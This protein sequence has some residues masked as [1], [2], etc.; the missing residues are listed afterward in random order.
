MA[1]EFEP[2]VGDWYEDPRGRVFEVVAVDEAEGAVEI[3]HFDG[4]VEEVDMDTW[5]ELDLQP[6]AEPKDWSG[7]FDDLERDDFGDVD[8]P[9]HPEA[10]GKPLDE[11]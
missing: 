5:V 4:D 10:W 1:T 9:R 6:T 11:L 8:T 3:Q 2:S 7:P